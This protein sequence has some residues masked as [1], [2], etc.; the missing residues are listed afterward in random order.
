MLDSEQ[1]SNPIILS[2]IAS[3]WPFCGWAALL[4]IGV[5][6]GCVWQQS[7][8]STS[9]PTMKEGYLVEVINVDLTPTPPTPPV[10]PKEKEAKPQSPAPSLQ[11]S[12]KS[13]PLSDDGHKEGAKVPL[14]PPSLTLQT[15]N[16][17][18]PYPEA[19]RENMIE[20][21]VT[22]VLKIEAATGIVQDVRVISGD[23]PACLVESV[24]MTVRKWRFHPVDLPGIIQEIFPFEF[25]L[26]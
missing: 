16:P 4:H 17:H 22:V 23:S 12:Q 25:L 8:I 5:I 24:M 7:F 21:K 11:R 19:A 13:I 2:P 14:V 18:P 20:G 3:I 6:G 26:H 15:G 10:K 9:L 1:S